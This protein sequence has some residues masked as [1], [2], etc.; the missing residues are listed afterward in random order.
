MTPLSKKLVIALAISGALNL[1]FLGL[2]AGS[3]LHRARVRADERALHGP[4]GEGGPRARGRAGAREGRRH[5]GPFAGLFAAHHEEVVARRR[6]AMA[7]RKAVEASLEREPFDPAAL[8]QALAALRK[9]TATTQERMH[10][11]ILDAARHGDAAMRKR[12]AQGFDR[13]VPP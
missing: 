1:L 7:A 9:E 6:A 4:R 8:E 12:L 11:V 5:G 3:L 13:A 2:F 10:E